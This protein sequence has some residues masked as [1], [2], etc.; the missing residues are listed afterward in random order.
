MG[1]PAAPI[2]SVVVTV[3]SDTTGETDTRHL[4]GCLAALARQADRP[5]AEILVTCDARLP[6]IQ[7]VERRFPNVKFVRVDHFRSPRH[8]AGREHHDELRGIGLRAAHGEIVAMLE[9]HGQPDPH[10]CAKLVEEHST[11]H[12]AIGGAMENGVDRPLNW[13]VYFSDFG[14][15]QNPVLRGPSYSLTDANVSYKRQALEK[16]ADAWAEAYNETRVHA[17]LRARG[18][19]LWI[20]PDLVVYQHR[21]NMRMGPALHERYVWG[22]S[23]AATRMENATAVQRLVRAALS[24]VLP[25]VLLYRHTRNV[26]SKG[27]N[28]AA[29]F[30]AFPLLAALT[31]AWATG[32]CVGY[33]TGRPA[34]D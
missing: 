17:A 2:L 9:D 5:P 34:A 32:E 12:A 29:F 31:I 4:E 15:Y 26:L 22:R 28:Q 8:G 19:T 6:G 10:W 13:A 20:S 25:L 18:E 33:L 30:R 3:V 24:P 23:Y 7:E 11:P 14:R 1:S 16:V 27:R 21:L